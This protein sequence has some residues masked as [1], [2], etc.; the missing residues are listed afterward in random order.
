M[1]G[2]WLLILVLAVAAGVFLIIYGMYRE[3]IKALKS[4]MAS[5]DSY[6]KAVSDL[7]LSG[8]AGL[9]GAA[10]GAAA[11][12]AAKSSLRLS[13]LIKHDAE[14][15]DRAREVA[16]LARQEIE[17]IK[18]YKDGL[19]NGKEELAEGSRILTGK[20]KKAFVRFQ[21]LGGIR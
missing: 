21:E 12:L 8:G 20:R 17:S 9:E 4:F 11:D 10:S 7:S 16:D 14:L 2:R 6:D 1:K 18:A 5:Y 3:D 15:M 13:S 19:Q